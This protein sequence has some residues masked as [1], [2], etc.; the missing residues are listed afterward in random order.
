MLADPLIVVGDWTT[1]TADAG[2]SLSLPASERAADHST[3][4]LVDVDSDGRPVTWTVFVGHQ[5]G[6]RSR[7]TVRITVDTVLPDLLTPANNAKVSQSVY[8]VAD[9]PNTGVFEPYS[10]APSFPSFNK[11][12]KQLGSFLISVDTADPIFRRVVDGE[13]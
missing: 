5:Y 12:M 2:E 11:M 6:K 9:V 1:V 8:V 13:T 7:Y 10:S 4:K 3:Y